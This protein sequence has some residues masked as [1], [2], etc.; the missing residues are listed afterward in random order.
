MKTDPTNKPGRR[1][2]AA[3]GLSLSALAFVAILTSEGYTDR[4]VIPTKNDRP[5][6]GFGSTFKEDGSAVKMGDTITP[7][8]AVQR[9]SAHIGREEEAFRASIA[10][11]P[12]YQEEYDLYLNWTYQYGLGAWKSS[13]MRRHLLSRNYYQACD[14]FL[15]YK[16]SGGFDCSIP[17]NKVCAGVWKRQLE[18][19]A[20]CLKAQTP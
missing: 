12:L 20:A 17:G 1:R 18:R 16:K 11:V 6:V 2:L 9:A 14:A 7:V 10:D 8:R 15:L 19:H 5:T 13:S 4:A 3:G